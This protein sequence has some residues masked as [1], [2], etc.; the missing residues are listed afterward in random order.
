MPLRVFEDERSFINSINKYCLSK[1]KM[2]SKVYLCVYNDNYMTGYIDIKYEDNIGDH[3]FLNTLY[4]NI[5]ENLRKF[6]DR[7]ETDEDISVAVEVKIITPGIN[8]LHV[9]IDNIEFESTLEE[10]EKEV[11]RHQIS[12][13]E[14]IRYSDKRLYN[15][16]KMN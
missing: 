3:A 16:E 2:N 9:E 8:T 5:C 7:S 11:K 10:I 1:D 4:S 14:K 12:K 15:I 13:E 6:K